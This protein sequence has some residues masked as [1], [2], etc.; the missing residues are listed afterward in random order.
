[1]DAKTFQTSFEEALREELNKAA[2]KHTDKLVEE[3]KAMLESVQ[4][5]TVAKIV[6]G[7]RISLSTENSV[8]QTVIR[9]ETR[10]K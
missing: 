2:K 6:E 4:L 9:I 1:M 8:G 10:T 3:F 5:E 7:I